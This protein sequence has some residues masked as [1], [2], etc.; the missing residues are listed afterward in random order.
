M[1]SNYY[2][3]SKKKNQMLIYLMQKFNYFDNVK[4]KYLPTVA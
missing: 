2:R 1:Y 3:A 4:A